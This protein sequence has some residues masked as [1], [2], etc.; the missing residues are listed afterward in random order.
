MTAAIVERGEPPLSKFREYR[1]T[2]DRTIRNELVE[3]FAPLGYGCARRF[4]NRGEP[5]D[6]L[7]QVALLGILKAVERFDPER[8]LPFPAFAVPTVLGELRRHFRDKGWMM[9]VPRRL[10]ELHLQLDDIV[11]ALSQRHGRAPTT[12]EVAEAAGVAEEDVLEAMEA[13]HCY[14]PSSIDAATPD[15]EPASS[16]LGTR[17][18][19]FN[20]VEDRATITHLLER[21]SPRERRVVYLRFFEDRTQSEIAQEIGVSQMHV[22]RLLSRSLAT[23]GSGAADAI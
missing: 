23:L 16:T 2:G 8:G 21:L 18:R 3:E 17:D 12:A 11:T 4:A 7:R 5:L 15:N 9:R 20:A 1:R 13:G 6:D 19:R 14:R 10:Q 22:S